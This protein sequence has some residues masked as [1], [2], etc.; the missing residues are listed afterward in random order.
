MEKEYADFKERQAEFLSLQD[1]QTYFVPL[2]T[3]RRLS[4]IESYISKGGEEPRTK[5]RELDE[6]MDD[7]DRCKGL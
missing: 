3:E 2:I 5:I 7:V 6:L 1:F 4:H